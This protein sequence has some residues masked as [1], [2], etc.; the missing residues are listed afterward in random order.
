M[1]LLRLR[2]RFMNGPSRRRGGRSLHALSLG[3]VVA[4]AIA[5]AGALTAAATIRSHVYPEP[6]VE[7]MDRLAA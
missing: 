3:F 1:R 2:H 5:L 6:A 7:P 4:A